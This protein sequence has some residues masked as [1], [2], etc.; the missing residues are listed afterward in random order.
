MCLGGF[1]FN[2]KHEQ[3]EGKLIVCRLFVFFLFLT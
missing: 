3:H 2:I 1:P